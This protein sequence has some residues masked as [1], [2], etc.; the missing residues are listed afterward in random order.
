[1]TAS[2]S[3]AAFKTLRIQQFDCNR[4]Q[5]GSLNIYPPGDL[6]DFWMC[7]FMT[8]IKF[9]EFLKSLRFQLL[10]LPIFLS[11]LL[12]RLLTCICWYVLWCPTGLSS[13][14]HLFFTL[15]SFCSSDWM[16][17]FDLSSSLLIFFFCLLKS[18]W[19]LLVYLLSI[20]SNVG[21]FIPSLSI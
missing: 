7:R 4:S 19:T 9:G 17:S 15:F 16:I 20:I 8:F 6:W 2:F 10:F 5:C 11:S 13:S 12:L 1:M 18:C 3:L 14:F 21:L